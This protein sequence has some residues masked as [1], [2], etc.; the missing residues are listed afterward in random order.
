MCAVLMAVHFPRESLCAHNFEMSEAICHSQW[1]TCMLHCIA[2]QHAP[3]HVG[4][5]VPVRACVCV[6][7]RVRVFMSVR[8]SNVRCYM[9]EQDCIAVM[10]WQT[11]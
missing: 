5:Q 8:D 3:E 6:C 1:V 9:Q 10:A 7:M 11:F 4:V 2:L